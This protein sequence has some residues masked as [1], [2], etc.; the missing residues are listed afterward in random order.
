MVAV[1]V[2][3]GVL[4]LKTS[5]EIEKATTNPYIKTTF[6]TA[7]LDA[8]FNDK[9]LHHTTQHGTKPHSPLHLP[10]PEQP[11]GLSFRQA[12]DRVHPESAQK[13]R[14][15]CHRGLERR[16]YLRTVQNKTEKRQT[17]RD[18]TSLK[19]ERLLSYVRCATKQRQRG[20]V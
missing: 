4:H 14:V 5:P 2:V 19:T 10:F 3:V 7:I 1:V 16:V 20:Q 6:T 15:G 9:P 13:R 8:P 11:K 12:T 17:H 18:Y